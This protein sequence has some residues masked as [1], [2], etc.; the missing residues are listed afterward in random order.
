MVDEDLHLSEEELDGLQIPPHSMSL[1]LPT[2]V[3]GTA[4][5]ADTSVKRILEELSI[6]EEFL[7]PVSKIIRVGVQ[8]NATSD[9]FL[10]LP[11]HHK[12]LAETGPHCTKR[13]ICKAVVSREHQCK[14]QVTMAGAG[15]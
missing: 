15:E 11:V 3:S 12:S 8:V 5:S 14:Y 10:H 4:P 1:P 13:K 9:D 6:S 7:S 2:D